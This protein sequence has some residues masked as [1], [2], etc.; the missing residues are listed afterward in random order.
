MRNNTG[1]KPILVLGGTGHYG[2]YIVRSLLEKGEP[3]RVLSRNAAN[4][5]KI[6]G[7]GPKIIE[8]DITSRESVV[9]S[10]NGVKAVVISV[11]AFT[12]KLIR[13]LKLIERDSVLMVMEEA[14]KAGV[15]RLVYISVYD[16]REDLLR[17]LNIQFG[18]AQIKLE[19]EAALAKSEFNWTVLGAAPS[20][21]IFFAM[22]RGDTMTVP[23]GG[24]PALPTV[25]P[26]DLGEIAAQTVLR[27]DLGG[28]RFRVT[29][30]EALSFPEAAKRISDVT[31]KTIRFR[32]IPLLP[33]KIVSV[34]VWPFNPYL[35]YLLGFVKLMNNFPQDIA[36]QIPVDHQLLVETFD[37]TPTTLEMEA[38]RRI[39]LS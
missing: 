19:I 16:I 21:E 14:Q 17:K 39:E 4:A 8:G 31:G 38:R 24:P 33:L 29:G 25:S 13:K 11:S 37:Y 23:G 28:K 6:L 26:V 34:L 9:E 32:K 15:S 7:D 35:R 1:N 20:M 10:L 30:P 5:R 12:P 18:S 36:A 22:I 3:V 2:R 27:Y